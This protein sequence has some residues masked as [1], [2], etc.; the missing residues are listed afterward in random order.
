[1]QWKPWYGF[2]WRNKQGER[3]VVVNISL[4]KQRRWVRTQGVIKC[5]HQATV[6]ADFVEHLYPEKP[7]LWAVF[8][9]M[10]FGFRCFH[11]TITFRFFTLSSLRLRVWL[12]PVRIS[13]KLNFWEQMKIKIILVEWLSLHLYFTNPQHSHSSKFKIKALIW[14]T[15]I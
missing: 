6:I 13:R 8:P 5:W 4:N 10:I 9:A 3:G 15:L 14:N 12:D 2:S 11:C 7:Q 1:M